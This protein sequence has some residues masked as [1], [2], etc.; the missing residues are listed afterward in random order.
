MAEITAY[1]AKT[2][3][4]EY[5]ARARDGEEF[6]ITNRGT[7][8]AKLVPILSGHDVETAREAMIRMRE[9]AKRLALN[10]SREEI[11]EWVNEGRM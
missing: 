4:S 1:D 6:V 5:L 10:I 7:P 2:H 11:R 3:F 8:V 9:R